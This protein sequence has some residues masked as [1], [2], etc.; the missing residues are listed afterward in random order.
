VG[1]ANVCRSDWRNRRLGMTPFFHGLFPL[2]PARKPGIRCEYCW[3]ERAYLET[4][5]CCAGPNEGNGRKDRKES[6]SPGDRP[7]GPEPAN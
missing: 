3:Q 6:I 1:D 5:V 7:Q 2:G 4:T